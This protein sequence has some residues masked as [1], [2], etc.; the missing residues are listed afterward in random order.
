MVRLLRKTVTRGCSA[1]SGNCGPSILNVNVCSTARGSGSRINYP[2]GFGDTDDDVAR[3]VWF[4]PFCRKE[5]EV[6]IADRHRDR[7][8]SDERF[9][10]QVGERD[11]EAPADRCGRR[12]HRYLLRPW[13]AHDGVP[14]D[15][16]RRG[17]PDCGARPG[18]R[19]AH[20]DRS[21]GYTCWVKRRSPPPPTDHVSAYGASEAR[22]STQSRR[23]SGTLSAASAGITADHCNSC[24]STGDHARK[25][26][27]LFLNGNTNTPTPAVSIVPMGLS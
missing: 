24:M 22:T 16:A 11:V 20:G 13:S 3:A 21:I 8:A 25:P 18:Q 19:G 7:F 23:P 5:E 6:A 26:A 17:T 1:G 4:G 2:I 15:L 14:V 27:H 12:A 9:A 10:D